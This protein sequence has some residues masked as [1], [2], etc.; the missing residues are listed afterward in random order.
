MRLCPLSCLIFSSSHLSCSSCNLCSSYSRVHIRCVCICFFVTTQVPPSGHLGR[1]RRLGM[2]GK[3][4]VTLSAWKCVV[5]KIRTSQRRVSF[6]WSYLF[7]THTLQVRVV[8]SPLSSKCR[9]N[10]QLLTHVVWDQGFHVAGNDLGVRILSLYLCQTTMWSRLE[11]GS[12]VFLSK[13][14]PRWEIPDTNTWCKGTHWPHRLFS[15]CWGR[16]ETLWVTLWVTNRHINDHHNFMITYP[17]S[18]IRLS[19]GN[20]YKSTHKWHWQNIQ[21]LI[22]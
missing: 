11:D 12:V 18:W 16:T 22:I 14:Y 8:T 17:K 21:L 3:L 20:L 6:P 13:S 1:K 19:D 7:P 10:V 15:C 5:D 9:V 4:S 2:L